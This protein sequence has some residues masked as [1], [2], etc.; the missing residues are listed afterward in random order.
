MGGPTNSCSQPTLLGTVDWATQG[1]ARE[2]FDPPHH[3]RKRTPGH[4]LPLSWSNTPECCSKLCK[5]RSSPCDT[6]K[7]CKG[8]CRAIRIRD[9]AIHAPAFRH[10]VHCMALHSQFNGN[11]VG[12]RCAAATSRRC[13]KRGANTLTKDDQTNG[14]SLHCS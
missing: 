4:S 3:L 12:V 6:N 2:V 7:F 14:P 10:D 5:V 9:V 13:R 8:S 11:V 1:Q